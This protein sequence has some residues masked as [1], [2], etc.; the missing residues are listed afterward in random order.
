MRL[1]AVGLVS[2][3]VLAY[4]VLLARLFS[5]IQWYH[6]AYM[7]ISIALL[8]YGAS[9]TFLALVQGRLQ[10]RAPAAFAA[11]AA[12]FGVSAVACFV[13]GERLPFNALELIWDP[14][15]LLYLGALY[16][17][18][19][20]PFFC[21]AVCIGLALACFAEP[22]GRIYRADLLGA[23][24]GALGILGVLFL[25]MPSR[26]LELV[27][28]LGLLAAALVSLGEAGRHGRLR[29]LL[30]IA[31][32]AA[33]L[34]ALPSAW[35]A[36]QLSPYKGLSQALRVP[37]A[38]VEAER[39]SPLGLLSAV[40]SPKIPFRHAPGL[41]LNNLLEPAAQIGVFTDGEGLSPIT[42]F[43]GD[44]EPLAYLDF[45]TAALPYHLLDRPAVLVLGAGGGADVL[46]ALHH[47]ARRIDAVELNSQL[48]DLVRDRYAEFAGHLYARP[49]VRLHIGEARGFVAASEDRYDLIQVP[50]LD[51]FAAAAAGTVSLN[52]SFVYT[53]E[54]FETYLEHLAPGGYLAITRWLKLP[55]RDSAKLFLT[56]LRALER[57]GV[58]APARQ[59]ALIRSWETTTLLV[60][61]GPLTPTDIAK[62]RAFADARSFDL[63]WYPGIAASE[64]NRYNLLQEPYFFAAAKGLIEDPDGF[65][66]RY[67]FDLRP[68]TDD[69]PYFF[70]FFRWRALPE[71]WTVAAQSGGALLDWGYLIL[72]ATL[73]QAAFLSVVLVLLPLWLGIKT[74]PGAGL[75]RIALYFGAIGLAFLFVEIASIQR[76]TLFLAHPLYAIG[77]VLAGFLTFAGLGSGVAPALERRLAGRRIEALALALAAIVALAIVYILALPPLFGALVG[78][79]DLAKI[80]LS[81]VLI[82][83][84]AFFMGMPFP[85]ALARLRASAPQLVPW[86]WAINGCASVLAAILATLLAM[87]FG[88]SAV[89]FLAAALYLI[90]GLAFAGTA[91]APKP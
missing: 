23:G 5:I 73:V 31:G 1:I 44:L 58:E 28:A 56:A 47:D 75:W 49:E 4:E 71:L 10:A 88:T 65:L 32:A 14:R 37:G 45:T 39:S 79:P 24:L 74:R 54:A 80:L 38:V 81:L 61:N 2:A 41:S 87:T 85:L 11:F 64:A 33:M 48:V 9:G 36:L 62:I 6:F 27:G 63:A 68:A 17:I 3:G 91:R 26:A 21:G 60:K 34:F 42:A 55:P 53:I 76:F 51:A 90:A 67:K 20:V 57:R 19:I 12:L 8:G 15:Q 72:A 13:L 22:V 77:V 84:L 30:Y 29:A 18:L 7:V 50:L 46:L 52:A 25:V 40:R 86:A 69:R 70:D 78:L 83:P 82:A 66:A 43:D 16:A 59:L 35:T 89:V